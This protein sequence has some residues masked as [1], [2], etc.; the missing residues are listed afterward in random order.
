MPCTCKARR[1]F[2]P[3]YEKRLRVRKAAQPRRDFREHSD[4]RDV[5]GELLKV[6][7]AKAPLPRESGLAYECRRRA[8]QAR[9]AR[10]GFNM[11]GVRLVST[12]KHLRRSSA[13]PRAQASPWARSGFKLYGLPQRRDRCFGLAGAAEGDS[14]FVVRG[15]PLRLLA[16]EGLEECSGGGRIARCTLRRSENQKPPRDDPGRP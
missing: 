8:K 16:S 13:D 5:G 14:E 4:C 9:I 3:P 11:P 1:E 7:R 10:R 12:G 15:R 2:E 6:V